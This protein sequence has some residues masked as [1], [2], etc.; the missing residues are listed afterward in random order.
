MATTTRPMTKGARLAF[1]GSL[2][3][4]VRAM[5]SSSRMAVPMTW[6]RNAPHSWTGSAVFPLAGRVE[7]TNCVLRVW[8]GSAFASASV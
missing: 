3:M 7:K 4:S 5:I 2:S 8:P 6:S 1:G